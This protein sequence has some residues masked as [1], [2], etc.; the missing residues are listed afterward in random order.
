MSWVLRP[1]QLWNE[2]IAYNRGRANNHTS[3]STSPREAFIITGRMIPDYD[4]GLD[5][6]KRVGSLC[7]KDDDEDEEHQNEHTD[8][9]SRS[10]GL[11]Q[12]Q[13]KF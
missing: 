1:R 6:R 13:Q 8:C 4:A 11:C 10:Y 9:D 5:M 7:F 12:N 3:I 2:R